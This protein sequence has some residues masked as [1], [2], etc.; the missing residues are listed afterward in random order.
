MLQV[1]LFRFVF[2]DVQRTQGTVAPDS[3]VHLRFYFLSEPNFVSQASENESDLDKV[4]DKDFLKNL[5]G[6]LK[7]E[8]QDIMNHAGIITK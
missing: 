6:N 7:K 3:N 5:P 2:S 4:S 1:F 8:Y